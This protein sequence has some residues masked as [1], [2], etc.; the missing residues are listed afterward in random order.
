MKHQLQISDVTHSFDGRY[1]LSAVSLEVNTGDI[2]GI[3]GR[4][5]SG[6]STLLMIIF[7]VLKAHHFSL[8]FNQNKIKTQEIIT[9]KLIGYLPQSSFLPK[10]K[11]VR[12]LIPLFF[13]ESEKQDKIFYAPRIATFDHKKIGHLSLGELRYLEFLI[14]AN[15]DH[16]FLLLDEPFSMI[17]PLYKEAIKE[18]IHIIK[19]KKGIVLTDHYFEDVLEITNKNYLLKN[20]KLLVVD[21]KNDLLEHNYLN[22]FK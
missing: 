22:S 7:G 10:S 17:E 8:D 14:L 18:Q 11:K 4:N 15:L 2:I 13:N 16:P 1:V 6:K 12:D 3:F 20:A 9:K 21:G 5:G 19:S